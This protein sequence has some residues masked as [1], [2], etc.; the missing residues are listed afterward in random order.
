[1]SAPNL[2]AALEAERKHR[3]A[4]KAAVKARV[5]RM[6]LQGEH[7]QLIRQKTGRSEGFIRDACAEAG[8]ALAKGRGKLAE[9]LPV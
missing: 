8:V 9:G 1:M 3:Q 2:R 7:V 5:V 4:E 6:A